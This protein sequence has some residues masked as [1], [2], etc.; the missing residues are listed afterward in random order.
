MATLRKQQVYLGMESD[1]SVLECNKRLSIV[2][3]R[4]YVDPDGHQQP[5][6]LYSAET[7]KPVHVKAVC[8]FRTWIDA[9]FSAVRFELY[10]KRR[11]CS[12]TA[13]PS[14]DQHLPSLTHLDIRSVSSPLT[15]QP[16]NAF[17]ALE[18]RELRLKMKQKGEARKPV[19]G[20]LIRPSWVGKPDGCEE[21]LPITRDCGTDQETGKQCFR[22]SEEEIRL[23]VTS[24]PVRIGFI[25][26]CRVS[27]IF[28]SERDWRLQCGMLL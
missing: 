2:G 4:L 17:S 27:Q 12:A 3:W 6:L 19:E 22:M 21:G 18:M 9:E 5:D 25:T 10:T 7:L 13:Q 28:I 8:G 23:S 26:L 16:Q 1:Q 20:E 15:I 14:Y 24:L 11:Q